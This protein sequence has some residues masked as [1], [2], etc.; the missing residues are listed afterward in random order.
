LRSYQGPALFSYGFR[1]FFLGG[2]LYGALAIIFWLPVYMDGLV[3]PTAFSPLAWHVH[4]MLFGFL[5]AIVTGF[6][7]TAVPNWTGR[8]PLRGAPLAALAGLWL[9][10]RLAIAFSGVLGTTAAAVIDCSFLASVTLA[11]T[12]EIA[13]GKNWRNLKVAGLIALLLAGNVLFHIELAAHGSFAVAERVGIATVILLIVLIGGRVVP[14]FTRNWLMQ[15]NPGRLPAPF[16]RT[17]AAIVALTVLAL[18]VWIGTGASPATAALFALA[19]AA[20]AWRLARWAGWR[21]ARYP[22]VLILHL[23]YAFVPFGFASMAAAMWLGNAALQSAGLHIWTAGAAGTMTLAIM[24]RASL[25]HTGRPLR[26]GRATA[27]IY[28]AV[29]AAALARAITPLF[30]DDTVLWLHAAAFLWLA[31]FGGFALVYGPML[32]RPRAA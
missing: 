3:L 2:A 21:A 12:W 9:A 8:T 22:L 14:A 10:G 1:P 28:A 13:K 5:P 23:G 25:G 27:G 24:T 17:D 26:A 16:D 7:L 19:G 29:I 20:Q 31:A 11:V 15:R 18:A 30:P 6:L 32:L 4:E